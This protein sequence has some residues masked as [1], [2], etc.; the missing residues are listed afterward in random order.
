[1]VDETVLKPSVQYN[2]E[3]H[4]L[5]GFSAMPRFVVLRNVYEDFNVSEFFNEL[6]IQHDTKTNRPICG[7][8]QV[9]TVDADSYYLGYAQLAIYQGWKLALWM[10]FN[11]I[12]VEMIDSTPLINEEN[13]KSDIDRLFA[14]SSAPN[15][16]ANFLYIYLFHGYI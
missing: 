6:S 15:S 3:N 14:E 1:M 2:I 11:Q 13:L 4:C 12:V 9:N 10:E 5:Y 16:E 7:I 8:V